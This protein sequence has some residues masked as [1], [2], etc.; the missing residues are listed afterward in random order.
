M[1]GDPD[2]YSPVLQPKESKTETQ[3]A[4]DEKDAT[5]DMKNS[6]DQKVERVERQGTADGSGCRSRL[7]IAAVVSGIALGVNGSRGGRGGG[8]AGVTVCRSAESP[9]EPRRGW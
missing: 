9:A 5:A 3:D 1:C 2:I 4:K 7:S 6:L 8:A